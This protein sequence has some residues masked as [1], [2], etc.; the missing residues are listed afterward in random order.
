MHSAYQGGGT[1]LGLL[2]GRGLWAPPWFPHFVWL[3][4]A[5][6]AF[7]RDAFDAVLADLQHGRLFAMAGFVRSM[8]FATCCRLA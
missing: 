2:F 1:H 8:S 4:K 3:V 6:L 7:L 5:V